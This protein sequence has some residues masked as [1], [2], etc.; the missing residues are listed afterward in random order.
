VQRLG[1]ARAA[2][3]VLAQIG[4]PTFRPAPTDEHRGGKGYEAHNV[5]VL[6]ENLRNAAA[7]GLAA[8]AQLLA[9]HS[10]PHQHPT[11]SNGHRAYS[12]GFVTE[13]VDAYLGAV[14][15][16]VSEALR[17]PARPTWNPPA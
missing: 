6:M 3:A 16:A 14:R 15:K 9:F 10:L 1:D 11:S 4:H 7:E 2:A 8:T 5:G 12:L 17:T 13:D